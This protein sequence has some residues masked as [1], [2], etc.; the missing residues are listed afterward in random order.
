MAKTKRRAARRQRRH[1]APVLAALNG[2]AQP[3]RAAKA[4]GLRYA[5]DRA[6][7][8]R[9]QR[10][11]SGFRYLSPRGMPIRNRQTLARIR[12]L[13]IPPAW[14][15]VW[16]CRDPNGHL[17]ATGRDSRGRKQYRYHPRWRVVRDEAKF[18]R[19]IAFARS[20]P[21]LRRRVQ[22]DLRRTGLPREKAL[23]ALVQ[24]L[25]STLIR[26]GND[27][28]AKSNHSF[29]LTTLRNR[30]AQ[31]NGSTIRFHFRGKSGISREIE[32]HDSRLAKIVRR[33]QDLP[34][35]ELFGYL[36]DEGRVRDIGSAD[37]NEYLRQATGQDFTAKD[38]RTWAGT[39]LALQALREL[40]AFDS[41]AAAKR[42]VV[43]AIEQ[44]AARLGNTKA[45]C[46][47]CYVHPAV[48]EAYL[49][50]SLAKA[51]EQRAKHLTAG[52]SGLPPEEAALLALL[53]HRRRSSAEFK[54]GAIKKRR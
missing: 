5:S 39:A 28:Y 48:I 15:D 37:V 36:D 9:R 7:G 14:Q 53:Q 54:R 38:F 43:R 29:G 40:E 46:R 17:Q 18:G 10:Q 3:S 44:V 35:Q 27:E 50:R 23:A 52:R 1:P 30:H 25:E 11:G 6:L 45:V 49:D 12:A 22:R 2:L 19:L 16:I 32:F 34:G 8:I 13:A 26:V 21:K 4:A 33:C 42:N 41:L 31:V 47:K 51:L 24:L 20:L